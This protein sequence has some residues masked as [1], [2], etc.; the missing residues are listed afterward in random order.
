MEKVY[1]GDCK[2][3]SY[4]YSIIGHPGFCNHPDSTWYEEVEGG[5]LR[6]GGRS[7]RR[8]GNPKEINADNDCERYEAGP[9]NYSSYGGIKK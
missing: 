3:F 7:C 6:P 4:S 2:F 1:C 5:Y 9:N 8:L